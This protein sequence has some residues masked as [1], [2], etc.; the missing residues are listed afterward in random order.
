LPRRICHGDPK[1]SNVMFQLEDATSAL[2][3][4][5]LDTVGEGYLAYEVGDALRSWC[6]P[7]G[8]DTTSPTLDVELF[9]ATIAGYVTR[10][11]SSIERAELFS[12]LEGFHTV[13]LELASRFAR[14]VIEDRYFG[15]D[16]QRFPSRRVH[17]LLRAKGQLALAAA[18]ERQRS[19]LA[20]ALERFA[21]R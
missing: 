19:E 3:W 6:N 9:R 13:S 12:V 17:N 18:I 2:C 21:P 11:G 14:D 7:A 8:E 1:L 16:E 5:D 4:L 15:W 20:H 10:G